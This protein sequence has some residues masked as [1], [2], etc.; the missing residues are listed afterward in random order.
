MARASV[1]DLRARVTLYAISG[2]ARRTNA[3]ALKLGCTTESAWRWREHCRTTFYGAPSP[4]LHAE[5]PGTYAD[6]QRLHALLPTE[7]CARTELFALTDRARA[8]V[9]ALR[10]AQPVTALDLAP[11]DAWWLWLLVRGWHAPALDLWAQPV[12]EAQVVRATQPP[13]AGRYPLR[14]ELVERLEQVTDGEIAAARWGI[15]VAG[16]RDH[17]ASIALVGGAGEVRP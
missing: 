1:H 16:G 4:V 3:P 12:D 13:S 17:D 10:R 9:A 5:L 11:H 14:P 7:R 6:E 2:R 15:V 8:L